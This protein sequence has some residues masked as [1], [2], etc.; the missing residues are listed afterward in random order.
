MCIFFTRKCAWPTNK[1]AWDENFMMRTG[2]L[3]LE[4]LRSSCCG[5]RCISSSPSSLSLCVCAATCSECMFTML[6]LQRFVRINVSLSYMK[7]RRQALVCTGQGGGCMGKNE[8][9]LS[10]TVCL[11]FAAA[12][13]PECNGGEVGEWEQRKCIH[14]LRCWEVKTLA[15]GLSYQGLVRNRMKQ[16]ST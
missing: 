1:L 7:W 8:E 3:F 15:M 4:C 10:S 6:C 2:Y 5:W 12:G 13:H 11:H 14:Y 16:Q 9:R